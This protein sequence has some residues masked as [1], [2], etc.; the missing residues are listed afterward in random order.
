MPINIITKYRSDASSCKAC[1]FHF[2]SLVSRAVRVYFVAVTEMNKCLYDK[3][4]KNIK[5]ERASSTH[6]NMSSAYV[7]TFCLHDRIA[8][9]HQRLFE[10]QR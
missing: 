6:N 4:A 8:G 3:L 5:K 10:K 7:E 1:C 2:H 9:R